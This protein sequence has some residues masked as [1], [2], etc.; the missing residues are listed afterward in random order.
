WSR[1]HR[2]PSVAPGAFMDQHPSPSPRGR[3]LVVGAYDTHVHVAPDVVPRLIDDL[4]LAR[5]FQE[6]GLAGFVLK[7]HYVP[8]TERAAVVRA[9]VSGVDVVGALTLNGSVGGMN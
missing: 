7:S 5:R 4:T 2:R 6:V 3:E 1:H 8:T 9:A